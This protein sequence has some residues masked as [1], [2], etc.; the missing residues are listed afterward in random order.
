MAGDGGWADLPVDL[1]SLIFSKLSL[2]HLFRS[3]A[4][5]VSWSA[6]AHE[7]RTRSG[8]LVFQGQSPWLMFG[9]GRRGDPSAAAFYSFYE[10]SEYTIALPDPPISRRLLIGSAHGWVI[11]VD[12]CSGLLQLLNPITGA[13]IDLPSFLS[14]NHIDLI[15]SD[16]EDC[17]IQTRQRIAVTK[18]LLGYIHLKATLSADPSLGGDYIVA[19]VHHLLPG[20]SFT[21]SGY[22]SWFWLTDSVEIQDILF[23]DGKLYA[24]TITGSVRVCVF[25]DAQL[26]RGNIPRFKSVVPRNDGSYHF[27]YLAETP[28]GDLLNIRRK[29]D[30]Y[31]GTAF[32]EVYRLLPEEKRISRRTEQMKDLGELIIFLGSNHPLCLSAS[33]FPHLTPNSIYFTDDLRLVDRRRMSMSIKERIGPDVGIY[34][35]TDHTYTRIFPGDL[36]LNWP[37]PVWF[38]LD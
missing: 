8:R 36:R 29:R 4:V 16:G 23:H 5:C 34:S 27:H 20:I 32:A 15:D 28:R 3:A 10:R 7:V 38:K 24:T 33:D 12:T 26:R 6:A 14:Y 11:T 2:P 31:R 9:G 17:I 22:Q 25:D 1:F 18:S 21:L 37:P 35:M 13:Q 19:L 30:R